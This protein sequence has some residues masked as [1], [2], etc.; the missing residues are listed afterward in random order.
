[1]SVPNVGSMATDSRNPD[2]K[3]VVL[4]VDDEMA[5]LEGIRDTCRREPYS[6]LTANSA[7]SAL[8]QL[9]K[10]HVDVIVSD[11]SMPEMSGSEL[12]SRVRKEY[13][14]ICRIMLT[15]EASL[16]VSVAAI[17]EGMYRF[18]SKPINPDELTRVV[19]AAI[20]MQSFSEDRARRAPPAKR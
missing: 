10:Q 12:L 5:V 19:R 8:E 2:P 1:V 11:Q 15:G 6:V 18:L 16:D 7:A 20:R 3:P 13:P 14:A 9:A 4:F 17:N